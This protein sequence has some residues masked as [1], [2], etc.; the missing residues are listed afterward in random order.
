MNEQALFSPLVWGWSLL[1]VITFVSLFF[2]TAPYGRHARGGWGPTLSAR[3]G[4][5]LME[6]PASL[7]VLAFTLPFA[8]TLG[9]VQ[10]TML[11]MW[12]LHYINRAFVYPMRLPKT[13]S[14]MPLSIPLMAMFFNG[15]NGYIQGRWLGSFGQ[16]GVEWFTDPRFLIG[17]GLFFFGFFGNLHSDWILRNLRKPGETGYKIPQGGLFRVVSSPNYMSEILEWIGW[18]VMTWSLAGTSFALWTIANLAPRAISNHQWY[19]KTFGDEYPKARKAL[20]PFI[21]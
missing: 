3:L 21:Y 8:A 1:A 2:I 13:A 6:A 11:A 14:A 17:L 16:Y 18:A 9:P 12:Q 7:L 10:W 20:V 5:F 19:Q 15:V 4:W